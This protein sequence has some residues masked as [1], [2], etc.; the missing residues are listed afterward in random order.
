VFWLARVCLPLKIDRKT[1]FKRQQCF[2]KTIKSVFAGGL[3][4]VL[5]KNKKNQKKAGHIQGAM[6]MYK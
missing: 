5:K 1:E 6:I 4:G 2:R 3:G